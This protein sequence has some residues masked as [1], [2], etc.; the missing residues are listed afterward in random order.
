VA[1]GEQKVEQSMLRMDYASIRTRNDE[2]VYWLKQGAHDMICIQLETLL[3]NLPNMTESN[4]DAMWTP[5]ECACYSTSCGCDVA[6]F[7]LR[8]VGVCLVSVIAA[9]CAP[10][11]M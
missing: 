5:C 2:R 10:I 9:R 7:Q 3:R 6:W 11:L 4:V 1:A 8:L